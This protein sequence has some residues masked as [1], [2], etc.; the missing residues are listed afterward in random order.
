MGAKGGGGF[1]L[2][3]ILIVVA[4]IAILASVVLVGVGPTQRE[5]R[6]S[7]RISDLQGVQNVLEL[8]NNHCGFYPGGAACAAGAIV[9]SADNGGYGK[10]VTAITGTPQV[11]VSQ[12]PEDPTNQGTYVYMYGS[13]GINSYTLGAQLEDLGNAVLRTSPS[14]TLNGVPCSPTSGVYCVGF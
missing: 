9:G 2:I 14:S 4:I 1:T 11:G 8:Y 12:V 6:D 10:M 3:E 13:N 5:G 7:R